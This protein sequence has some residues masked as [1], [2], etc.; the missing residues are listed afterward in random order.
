MTLHE[1]LGRRRR[2]T[3]Q[4]LALFDAGELWHPLPEEAY[5]DV[6]YVMLEEIEAELA[7]GEYW[8]GDYE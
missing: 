4:D 3:L 8:R 6:L 5:R 1:L 7:G 2:D